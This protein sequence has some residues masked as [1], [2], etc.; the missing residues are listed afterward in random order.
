VQY[1]IGAPVTNSPIHSRKSWLDLHL[2]TVNQPK[3]TNDITD[4]IQEFSTQD[5]MEPMGGFGQQTT[6]NTTSSNDWLT[7][8]RN[9]PLE[10]PT[11]D[12]IKAKRKKTKR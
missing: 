9:N 1:Q 11:S 5:L 12:K 3:K 8:L 2:Q 10:H 4:D 7:H 6:D